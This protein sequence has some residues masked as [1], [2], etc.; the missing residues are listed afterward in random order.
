MQD[1][2]DLVSKGLIS[3]LGLNVEWGKNVRFQR[4]LVIS[5]KR[6]EIRPSLLLIT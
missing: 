5:W 6:W 3:N 4:K 2:S 1:F